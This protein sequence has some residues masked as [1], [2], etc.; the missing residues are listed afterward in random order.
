VAVNVHGIGGKSQEDEEEDDDD[1]CA[2]PEK[3]N[4]NMQF[5]S[6]NGGA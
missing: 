3:L 5:L 4:P 1:Q 2:S 6:D